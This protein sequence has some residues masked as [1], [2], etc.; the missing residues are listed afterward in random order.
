[1]VDGVAVFVSKSVMPSL[2][3]RETRYD[4]AFATAVS[5]MEA[6][7]AP[8]AETVG[9]LGVANGLKLEVVVV[10]DLVQLMDIVD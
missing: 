10:Q 4:E 1:M 6:E 3:K 2:A 8:I 9:A 7:V 5:V